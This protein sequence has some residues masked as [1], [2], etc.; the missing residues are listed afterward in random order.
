M[1]FYKRLICRHVLS[2]TRTKGG[3]G[4]Q[5]RHMH[6]ENYTLK[7]RRLSLTITTATSYNDWKKFVNALHIHMRTCRSSVCTLY[8]KQTIVIYLRHL[9][10]V[11]ST[12]AALSHRQAINPEPAKTEHA[13]SSPEHDTQF[14]LSRKLS[15]VLRGEN[16]RTTFEFENTRYLLCFFRDWDHFFPLYPRVKPDKW[17]VLYSS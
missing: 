6:S 13:K 11:G 12:A 3:I 8:M 16:K 15:L 9:L 14:S 10:K 2:S 5:A 4:F 1:L 7:N 17:D